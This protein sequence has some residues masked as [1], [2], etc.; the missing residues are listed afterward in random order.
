MG[1]QLTTVQTAVT[2]CKDILTRLNTALTLLST[3]A[4]SSG[5][6][7]P[8]T[9]SGQEEV[10]RIQAIQGNLQAMLVEVALINGDIVS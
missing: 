10:Q 4:N 5:L 9:G 6:S 2:N 7:F 8:D 3:N 1:K